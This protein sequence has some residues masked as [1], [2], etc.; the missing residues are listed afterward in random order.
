MKLL[1]QSSHH[2][3][4]PSPWSQLT[5]PYY[6]YT[7]YHR[8]QSSPGRKTLLK[9]LA[10]SPGLS[11][12]LPLLLTPRCPHLG[13]RLSTD[14][15]PFSCSWSPG[16]VTCVELDFLCLWS[17]LCSLE[18]APALQHRLC[19]VLIGTPRGN[20]CLPS[21][22]FCRISLSMFYP[23]LR[24][25]SPHS[26]CLK[27]DILMLAVFL[28]D[29]LLFAHCSPASRYCLEGLRSSRPTPG[30]AAYPPQLHSAH[31][32]SVLPYPVAIHLAAF[33][34]PES[35]GF[36]TNYTL[37]FNQIYIRVSEWVSEVAQSCPTLCDP[38]DC[39]L[40][41]S[42]VHGIFQT[43]VLEWVGISFSKI[44]IY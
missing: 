8:T 16:L 35:S 31:G 28:D 14:S 2:L 15:Q 7:L 18:S 9:A 12:L 37:F 32:Q 33:L 25:P 19:C 41:G 27:L 22:L 29:P 1:L 40:P 20:T 4:L 38:I 6:Q 43:R 36:I 39:S 44:G 21:A 17:G 24:P 34:C 11:H 3:V 10:P 23:S 30:P 13:P 42:S 26:H 5:S